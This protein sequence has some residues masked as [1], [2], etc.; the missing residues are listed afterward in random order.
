MLV[1]HLAALLSIALSERTLGRERAKRLDGISR[2]LAYVYNALY[3]SDSRRKY[4]CEYTLFT[5]ICV[6]MICLKLISLDS[7]YNW[8]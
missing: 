6:M 5:S 4:N 8:N 7:V 1:V 3:S 2:R